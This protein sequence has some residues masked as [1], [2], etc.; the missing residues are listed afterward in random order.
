MKNTATTKL[1]WNSLK[2]IFFSPVYASVTVIT[3]GVVLVF[4]IWLP[5]LGLIWDTIT[6]SA[7]LGDKLTFLWNSLGAIGTNFSA[8]SAT[9]TVL[10]SVLLG[11][12]VS[13]TVAYFKKRIA[14]QKSSGMGVAGM[15]AGLIGVGCASC[16]SVVLSLFIGVGGTAALT[17]FLP[18][19]GQE[20]SILAIAILLGS[21]YYTAKKSVNPLVCKVEPKQ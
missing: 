8:L 11:M 5:N 19:A 4:S 12:N 15:L 9:L 1:I 21:F 3:A 20:F 14:F 6:S 7:S 2:E 13:L 16:G 10:V 17:G 18:L